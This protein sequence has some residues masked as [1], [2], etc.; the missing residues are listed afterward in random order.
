MLLG[1]ACSDYYELDSVENMVDR[2]LAEEPSAH[3]NIFIGNLPI[4]RRR[5]ASN[6]FACIFIARRRAFGEAFYPFHGRDTNRNLTSNH[7]R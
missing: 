7:W 3:S 6:R 2:H 5:I 4:F 1:L